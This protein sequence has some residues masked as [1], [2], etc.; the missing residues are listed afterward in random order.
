M[1]RRNPKTRKPV[2][3]INYLVYTVIVIGYTGG[4]MNTATLSKKGWVV[5]PQ[6]LREKYG[7]K[8][9]DKVH[10]IDYGGVISIMSAAEN[11]I[12]TSMGMLKGKS[13]LLKELS[14]SRQ[15]DAEHER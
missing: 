7:L 4:N 2:A 10:V 1:K 11:P 8:Q 6:E 13:S 9:G 12:K 3:I 14:K 15:K 5:I